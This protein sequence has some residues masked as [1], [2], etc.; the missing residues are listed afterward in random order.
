MGKGLSRTFLQRKYTNVQKHINQYHHQPSET[1]VK[2]IMKYHCTPTREPRLFK[3][4]KA[5]GVGEETEK[6]EALAHHCQEWKTCPASVGGAGWRLLRKLSTDYHE[7][8]ELRLV[9]HIPERTGNQGLEQV[10]MPPCS[11]QHQAIQ[12][13]NNA[14]APLTGERVS[15]TR[16]RTQWNFIQ[17]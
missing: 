10:F 3:N 13:G 1:Q 12:P 2:T 17:P 7:I 15:K 11:Q 4:Q 6:S 5:A 9:G 8:Q 16:L 14:K